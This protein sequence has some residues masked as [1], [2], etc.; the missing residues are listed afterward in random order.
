MSGQV[1]LV[2]VLS[3]AVHLIARSGVVFRSHISAE[4]NPEGLERAFFEVASGGGGVGVGV[5]GYLH[6]LGA[7]ETLNVRL[8]RV[9]GSEESHNL[10]DTM[11]LAHVH[12]S[13][14]QTL[15]RPVAASLAVKVVVHEHALAAHSGVKVVATVRRWALDGYAAPALPFTDLDSM[16]ERS[17]VVALVPAGWGWPQDTDYFLDE[18]AGVVVLKQLGEEVREGA[19]GVVVGHL[20]QLL[21]GL[22]G[23]VPSS[24]TSALTVAER[25]AVQL[26]TWRRHM[27]VAIDALKATWTLHQTQLHLGAHGVTG[28]TSAYQCVE[29]VLQEEGGEGIGNGE[30]AVT[31]TAAACARAAIALVTDPQHAPDTYLPLEHHLALYGPFWI[32]LL[33]PLLQAMK[34]VYQGATAP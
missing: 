21:L 14:L 18:A 12:V 25:R 26:S 34:L 17:V 1:L 6:R 5:G 24:S 10:S 19:A 33:V 20:R 3:I 31:A 22:P 2:A 8:V 27:R 7:A 29:R 16:T 9:Y 32:P 28:Y 30:G 11:G 23:Q 4:M 15:L 13:A